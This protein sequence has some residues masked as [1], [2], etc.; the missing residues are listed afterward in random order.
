MILDFS[1][2]SCYN[3]LL[4]TTPSNKI[5]SYKSKV[6]K[7]KPTIKGTPCQVSTHPAKL[8]SVYPFKGMGSS[9]SSY[10]KEKAIIVRIFL[11]NQVLKIVR[12]F[13]FWMISL[14]GYYLSCL[15]ILWTFV[16]VEVLSFAFYF[17]CIK[18]KK[19]KFIS[20]LHISF[21]GFFFF[22]T[23]IFLFGSLRVFSMKL[24]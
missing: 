12:S 14:Q 4:F 5:S 10:S 21:V 20:H 17:T 23:I 6:S 11:P 7:C 15:L 19:N 24:K 3:I 8:A 22:I 16:F 1:Q 13:V 2:R 18:K 9:T